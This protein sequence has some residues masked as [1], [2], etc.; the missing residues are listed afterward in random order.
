[1][2]FL[3]SFCIWIVII[4]GLWLYT[5]QKSAVTRLDVAPVNLA[6]QGSFSVELTPTF[7]VEEDPFALTIEDSPSP[8]IQLRLNGKQVP[9]PDLPV[10]RGQVIYIDGIDAVQKGHND[11]YIQASPPVAESGLEHGIRVKILADGNV[12]GDDTTWSSGGALISESFHFEYSTGGE[13]NHDH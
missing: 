1:M 3:I 10:Q 12:I 4:G 9:L 5:S 11:I 13:D 8:G 2:R 6:V 7:S